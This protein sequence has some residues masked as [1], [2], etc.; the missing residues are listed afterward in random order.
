[1]LPVS[2]SL[3]KTQPLLLPL[4]SIR[5]RVQILQSSILYTILLVLIVIRILERT[6]PLGDLVY[7]GMPTKPE[8]KRHG[9]RRTVMSDG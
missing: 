7:D 4:M 3:K 2:S 8:S 9:E 5:T 6:R 1:L